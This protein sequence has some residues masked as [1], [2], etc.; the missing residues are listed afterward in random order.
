M[1]FVFR[2]GD[3]PKLDPQVDRGSDFTAWKSQ[4][5][6]YFSL[7]GLDKQPA[8]KQVQALTLCFSR[9]TVTVVD[10]LGMTV[11]QRGSV[12]EII[13]AIEQYVRGQLNESVEH[14]NFKQRVQQEG[15]SFD[16]FLVALRELAK[17]CN[18][19]SDECIQKNI[20]DQVVTGLVDGDTVEDL[21]KEKKL[22]LETTVSKCR[23]H[24]MAKRQR[25]ELVGGPS[26]TSVQA[27]QRK[28]SGRKGTPKQTCPGCG[29]EFH[30]GGRKQCPAFHLSCHKCKRLGHMAKV[31]RW[32]QPTPGEIQDPSTKALYAMSPSVNSSGTDGNTHMERAPTVMVQL[33]TLNGSATVKALPDSGADVSVAGMAAVKQLGVH[34]DS[35]LPSR[36]MPRTVSGH[37]M[38]P[39]GK[40]PVKI[41]LGELTHEDHLH[42][43]PEVSGVLLSW[44]TC[45][46]L[47]ILPARYPSQIC[48]DSPPAH[49]VSS[50][51]AP[52]KNHSSPQAHLISEFPEIFN[53]Q[54]KAMQGEEFHIQLSDDAKPF[55]VKIPRVIP[56]A[57]RDKLKAELQT[58]QE[59]GIITP[60]THPTEWCAP[61]VVTP[62]KDTDNIRLCVD[63]SRLNRYVKR[64]RY[65]S[66]TPAQAVADIAAEKAQVF[67]KLDAMKGYHQ[68]P[69]DQ[70]SQGLTTFITPFGRF[71]FL[72]AL[73]GL[74]SIS[75]HYNRRMDEIFI[76]LPGFRRV[77]D[78]VVIYDSDVTQHTQHVRQFLQRC[79]EKNITLNTSKWKFAQPT[80]EFAGFIL[81][82]AGYQVDPTI[83]Q[84]ITKFPTPTNRTELRSFVGL[85]NQLSASTPTIATLLAPLRPLLSTQNE[86]VWSDEFENSFGNIK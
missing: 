38:K 34:K 52:G 63:L 47:K 15:E 11:A 53:G 54:V 68:C 25:M 50:L 35:L 13:S 56:F 2:H 64:E 16:D 24:E 19:C 70:A 18:F 55:F 65:H 77:V 6:A 32:R 46:S 30:P 28:P 76:G 78:D 81:S 36:V 45:R 72:R 37:K 69:I 9:E 84:A 8:N 73:Y 31:C 43:Y 48:V 80:I 41:T 86:F 39:M 71:K 1:E 26:A 44:Q 57:Y 85:V 5:E 10:N 75:E 23:A 33:S 74:S 61:I 22:T 82:P 17:T 49:A 59:Q 83:T 51:H 60:V 27:L 42:I 29:S 12:D 62:K 14:R 4:W 7:S 20:R 67:T 66:A 40:L 58:L 79:A 3:L 21:L